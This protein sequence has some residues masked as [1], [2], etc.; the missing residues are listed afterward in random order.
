MD[1]LVLYAI[2]VFPIFIYSSYLILTDIPNKYGFLIIIIPYTLGAY[3]IFE[4][5]I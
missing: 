4:N 5:L 2:F 3:M 1:F